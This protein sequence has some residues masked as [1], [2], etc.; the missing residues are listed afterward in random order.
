MYNLYTYELLYAKLLIKPQVNEVINML[1]QKL[2][3]SI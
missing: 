1:D 3:K 2:N